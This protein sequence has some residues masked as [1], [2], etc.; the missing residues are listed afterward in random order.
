MRVWR[1]CAARHAAKTLTGRGGL[2]ASGRWHSQ[3]RPVVYTSASLS[4]AALEVL[5]H[6]DR[7]L[8]PP[9]LTQVEIEVPDDVAVSSLGVESLP[10]GWRLYPAPPALRELGERWLAEGATLV[11]RVPSAVIPQ[12]ADYLLNPLHPGIS[13][14]AVVSQEPFVYGTRSS[15]TAGWCFRSSRLRASP[16]TG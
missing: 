3:G 5:V 2:L 14:V 7:D 11:L 8:L 16:P 15:S 1:I 13:R 9:G 4:L 10:E 12:E 6:V